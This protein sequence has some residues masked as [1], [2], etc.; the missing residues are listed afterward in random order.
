MH[1]CPVD[2]CSDLF[3]ATLSLFDPYQSKIL[4][5]SSFPGISHPGDS[6][7]NYMHI[8]GLVL[9]PYS[10]SL[11]ILVDNGDPSPRAATTS[12]A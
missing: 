12:P 4:N 6:V 9:R 11:K 5:V 8:S 7:E 3:N 10:D 1:C 2:A